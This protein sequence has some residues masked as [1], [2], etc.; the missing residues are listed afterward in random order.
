MAVEVG[1]AAP[2]F[3]LADTARQPRS[4]KEFSGKNVVLAFFPGAFT[5]GCTVEA[6]TFR[7]SAAQLGGVNAQVVGVTVDSPIAQKAWADANQLTFPILSDHGRKVIEAYG[8]GFPNLL[9]WEGYTSSQRAV[10]VIDKAGT[11]RYK[12]VVA[13]SAQVNFEA[14]QKSL[15][16]L[17]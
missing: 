3:T 16:T 6:C 4:L 9:G 14:I 15:S 8:V 11:V 7:D 12:E 5:G 13:P 2:D 1:Q 10:F 17:G